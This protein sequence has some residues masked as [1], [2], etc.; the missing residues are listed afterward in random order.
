MPESFREPLKGKRRGFSEAFA[1]FWKGP[2]WEAPEGQ[3]TE[4]REKA[5]T[6]PSRPWG[7]GSRNPPQ[8]GG[9]EGQGDPPGSPENSMSLSK[10]GQPGLP[11]STGRLYPPSLY[12]SP[13]SDGVLGA[14]GS[15]AHVHGQPRC[16]QFR[17]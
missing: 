6:P 10:R 4:N 5:G 14:C 3:N 17:I 2:G 16:R 8:P 13:R 11:P 15:S 9:P 1:G 12:L 7:P